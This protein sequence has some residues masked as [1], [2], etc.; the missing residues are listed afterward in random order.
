MGYVVRL[1]KATLHPIA[2]RKCHSTT[3]DSSAS[4]L[5]TDAEID[6]A[7]S[8]QPRDI[9]TPQRPDSPSDMEASLKAQF[10]SE[11]FERAM[12]TLEQYGPEEGLRRLK[13]NDP[14]V[15]KR[16]EQHRNQESVPR[17]REVSR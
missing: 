10:P 4:A 3:P 15:A 12:D 14:E 5:M 13:E 6:A 16:I 1:E 11:R 7:M 8:S 17:P 2:K 9:P